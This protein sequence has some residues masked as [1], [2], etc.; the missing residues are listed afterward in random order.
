MGDKI[1]KID[2]FFDDDRFDLNI[3]TTELT[4]EEIK[5]R[6]EEHDRVVEENLK[7]FPRA[8]SPQFTIDEYREL[9]LNVQTE[10]TMDEK[11]ELLKD[12]FATADVEYTPTW[13]TK[14]KK[15]TK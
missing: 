8:K 5:L 6:K 3:D 12:S 7:S 11:E 13:S 9:I 14:L 2:E 15:L 10:F 4:E 1:K